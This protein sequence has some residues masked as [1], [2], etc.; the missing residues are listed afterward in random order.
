MKFQQI[1]AIIET[2]EVPVLEPYVCVSVLLYTCG[3]VAPLKSDPY[4]KD[5]QRLSMRSD[6]DD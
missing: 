6:A 2:L 1:Y 5:S 3:R 4:N